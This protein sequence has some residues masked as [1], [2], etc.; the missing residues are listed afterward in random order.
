MNQRGWC[1][2]TYFSP[3][4]TTLCCD[5][6]EDTKVV[7]TD[8]MKETQQFAKWLMTKAGAGAKAVAMKFT[9]E[10]KANQNRRR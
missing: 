5:F 10:M 4:C 1:E 7:E 6:F 9:E 8:R 2:A 3:L